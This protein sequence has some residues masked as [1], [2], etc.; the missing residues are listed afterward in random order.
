M[1]KRMKEDAR[2][3]KWQMSVLLKCGL[4]FFWKNHNEVFFLF[5]FVDFYCRIEVKCLLC[6]WPEQQKLVPKGN[7]V[8]AENNKIQSNNE[9]LIEKISHAVC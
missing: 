7:E 5:F 8:E 1:E 9:Y 2:R 3:N 6:R 4:L